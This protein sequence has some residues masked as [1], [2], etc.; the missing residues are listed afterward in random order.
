[1]KEIID[2]LKL[3][4]QRKLFLISIPIITM[5]ATFFIV[6]TLPDTYVAHARIATG[7]VDQGERLITGG[8]RSDPQSINQEF[9]NLIQLMGLKMIVNQ[10]SYKLMLHDLTTDSAFRER[11]SLLKKYSDSQID[12]II[13]LLQ[14]KYEKQEELSA[15]NKQERELLELVESMKYDENSISKKLS[16]YRV[17]NSDFIDVEFSAE[18]PELSAFVV[19][20]LCSEFISY[21]TTRIK[22]SN[23]RTVDFLDS[24]LRQRQQELTQTMEALKQYKI[25]NRVLNLGEQAKA[26]YGQI[27]DFETRREEATQEIIA[28]TAALNNIESKFDPADRKY[29]ESTLSTAN[30]QIVSIKEQLKEINNVYIHSNFD[31]KHKRVMD[32]LKRELSTKI[33]EA[34]DQYVYNP[35]VAREN[36]VEQKLKMEVAL[37]L[38]KNS[39]ESIDEEIERL[40]IK[41][42]S[43]VPH[44]AEIQAY[45]SSIDITGR[46]YIEL[47]QKYN[48]ASIISSIPLQLRQ[49]ETAEPGELLASKKMMMVGFAGVISLVI[50]IGVFFAIFLLDQTVRDP[51]TLANTTQQPVLGV[52]TNLKNVQNPTQ[53]WAIEG[54]R[55]LR[56]LR[57]QLRLIR[58][59]LEDDLRENKIFAVTG[60]GAN[61]GKDAIALFIAEAM[62]RSYKRVL[63]ID[64]DFR[65]DTSIQKQ[66]NMP[67]LEEFIVNN[68]PI[69]VNTGEH[70]VYFLTNGKND[71]ALS[72]LA[73]RPTLI[74][75]L[76]QLEGQ[77][78]MI[79]VITAPL[80][81]GSNARDWFNYTQCT[82][83]IFR[84]GRAMNE[85]QKMLVKEMGSLESKFTGWILNQI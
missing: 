32:S 25:H 42:D 64:G 11:S 7:I 63:V 54:D 61:S 75:R 8:S 65:N 17:G 83:A 14:R 77:F 18:D 68:K 78:D 27:A 71:Q 79:L 72:E 46:E 29:L 48:Q 85:S 74:S 9:E 55:Q 26:L 36:L 50:C 40:N 73:D 16:I 38:A 12:S 82:L 44:E 6:R 13:R 23:I 53:I 1:M 20:N 49:I 67:T 70:G 28:Y 43:L 62:A 39:V 4:Y 59:E 47:L 30:Q 69:P 60:V 10:V 66:A 84:T 52:L 41:F 3:L 76:T 58:T 21:Y 34:S 80:D 37:E 33:S 81:D 51:E 24:L 56:Q 15:W 5:I 35:M 22:E 2:F 45:E 31:P 57:D 19:N